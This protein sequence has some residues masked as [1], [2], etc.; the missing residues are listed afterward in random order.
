M[1]LAA[2]VR[3]S[4]VFASK[5][6][7]F[8]YTLVSAENTSA[9]TGVVNA[10][11]VKTGSANSQNVTGKFSNG[12]VGGTP[13]YAPPK[14]R[15][16]FYSYGTAAQVSCASNPYPNQKVVGALWVDVPMNANGSYDLAH[17]TIYYTPGL[18]V[19]GTAIS[20]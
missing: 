17:M 14:T 15:L 1:R 4:P 10:T 16:A 2:E 8:S 9:T 6:G 5:A 18:F 20:K 3:Q 12:I 13:F 19:N 7:G 11:L